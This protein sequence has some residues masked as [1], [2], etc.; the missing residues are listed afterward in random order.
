MPKYGSEELKNQAKAAVEQAKV[1]IASPPGPPTD[2]FALA[3]ALAG[4][5]EIDYARKVLEKTDGK[6]IPQDDLLRLKVPKQRALYTYKDQD[7]PVAS[8]LQEAEAILLDLIP[9]ID[10]FA[11]ASA[12]PQRLK[13]L[14]ELKQDTWGI[15]G[16]VHKVRFTAFASRESLQRSLECYL[17]G[18]NLGVNPDG[19][20]YT[21][22]NAAFIMDLLVSHL[23]PEDPAAKTRRDDAQ[24][25]RSQILKVLLDAAA[26]KDFIADQWHYAK[27]TEA[28]LGS[29]D[30]EHAKEVAQ[31]IDRDNLKNWEL[32]TMARQF[33]HIARLQA[34]K[35]GKS[36]KEIVTTD[37]WSVVKI[38]LG[39]NATAALSFLRGKVGLALSGGG[40]RAS[41]YHIGVLASLAEQDMLRHVEVISCV[42]GGSIVGMYYYL[43]LRELLQEKPDGEINY[44][45][46]VQE[47]E[48]EFL[49]GVQKNLRMRAFF[50]L[51]SNFSV[52]RSRHSSTTNRLGRLYESK[53]YSKIYA[54]NPTSQPYYMDEITIRPHG[55]PDFYPRYDN[56][57]RQDKVPILV[58]NSTT[59][60]T[61]HSWQFTATFMGEPPMALE[62]A[63]IDA[64][65]RLRRMYYEEAPAPYRRIRIGDAVAASA[66]VPGLFEPL[67]L[68]GLYQGDY[69][70]RLVDG[71]VF[72]N[73]GVASLQ[74]QD[75]VV[76]LVSDASGQTGIE[77]DP[78]GD[79]LGVSLRANDVLMARIR[80]CEHQLLCSLQEAK[81]LRGLM[82]VHLK[83]GL[84][85][86]PIDWIDTKDPSPAPPPTALTSYR[87]RQDVQQALASVRTDLGS[88]SNCE[89]DA[90]MLS[91]YRTT[92]EELPKSIS[93][94]PLA[95][96]LANPGWRFLSISGIASQLTSDNP[97]LKGLQRT[98]EVARSKALKAF[99]LLRFIQAI[100]AVGALVLLAILLVLLKH[101]WRVRWPIIEIVT[102]VAVFIVFSMLAQLALVRLLRYR[103]SVLQWLAS[104]GLL[105]G[106]GPFLWFHLNF[107]DRYYI[108]WGPK[109]RDQTTAPPNKAAAARAP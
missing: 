47:M 23:P 101:Y 35:E 105:F 80:E 73:Q 96:P 70:V 92:S 53:I 56:W 60:N 15:L 95:A 44:M 100:N 49:D 12:S 21:G 65:D 28:Y 59:L 16:A 8:R 71:G 22:L 108:N 19:G 87:I 25:I 48:Q 30:Y 58:L 94:F 1:V 76:M 82:F 57:Q 63:Q 81:L 9:R 7:L 34:Q 50:S 90:L 52:L 97:D 42:S 17:A 86:K 83:K 64:N 98:L 10:S 5:N 109:Y 24:Q 78:S 38:L 11:P 40:F 20:A 104:L 31:K 79:H 107:V 85:G 13:E 36:E 39:G 93:G 3:K 69:V 103:N 18:Y 37:T 29:G 66:C 54:K 67:V 75:C 55:Q 46:L 32:E 2:L 27:L 74:E 106:G 45:K 6:L 99:K 102:V 61:C 68:D 89:A 77:T 72:D 43:K 14:L 26:E 62:D 88:F 41:L 91:G 33:T 84:S 51:G 4:F